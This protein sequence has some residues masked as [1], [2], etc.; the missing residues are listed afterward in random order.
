MNTKPLS[1]T[2]EWIGWLPFFMLTMLICA[3]ALADSVLS[4]KQDKFIAL[5]GN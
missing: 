3:R 2:W 4:W 1:R 5:K